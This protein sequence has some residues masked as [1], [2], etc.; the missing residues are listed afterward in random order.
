MKYKFDKPFTSE[1]ITRHEHFVTGFELVVCTKN[2]LY[3]GR[4]TN[5]YSNHACNVH[6]EDCLRELIAQ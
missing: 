5:K 6:P 3:H 4:C 1:M 2:C